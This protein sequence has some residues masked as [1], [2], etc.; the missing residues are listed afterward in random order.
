[1]A[2]MVLFACGGAPSSGKP[3]TGTLGPAERIPNAP[4]PDKCADVPLFTME[5]LASGMGAGKLVAVE[6]VPKTSVICTLLACPNSQCCN[7]CGG[8]YVLRDNR[9]HRLSLDKLGGCGGMDCNLD[10]KPFGRRPTRRYRFV[11][12]HHY[13]AAGKTSVY[14]SSRI[15]V[16]RYCRAK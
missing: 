4:G 7:S 10:C 14:S 3:R 6:G 8:S 1:M 11:G 12:T 13:R 9:R 16:V 15:E 2:A 5:Q